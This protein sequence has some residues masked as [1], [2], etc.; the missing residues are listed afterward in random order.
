MFRRLFV[1]VLPTQKIVTEGEREKKIEA[2]RSI[3]Q[4]ILINN[5]IIIF[6]YHIYNYYRHKIGSGLAVFAG[7]YSKRDVTS[8]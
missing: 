1:F 8:K 7:I 5:V 2:S 3:N 6:L 4:I